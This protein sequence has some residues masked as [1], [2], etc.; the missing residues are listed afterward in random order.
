MKNT[1]KALMKRILFTLGILALYRLGSTLP[2]PGIDT[3]AMS[4]IMS[5]SSVF[6]VL[7]MI[8]GGALERMSL[9]ALGVSPY[10]TA[11]IIIELLSM[12]VIPAL[13]EWRKGG[14]PG[15]NKL[16]NATRYLG[17]AL[18]ALQ[19]V[20]IVRGFDK[21]YGILTNSSVSSYLFV[22]TMLVAGTEML[23]WLGD[24]ITERGIGNGMSMII[25]AGIVANLPAQF[26]GAF[27]TLAS[28]ASSIT[29][30]ILKFALYCAIYLLLIL[31]VV[32][33]EGSERRIP[34]SYST[35]MNVLGGSQMNY[36]P[37]KINSASVIPVIFAASVITAPQIILS[38][39]NYGAYEKLADTLS[40]NKPLGLILYAALTFGFTFFYTDLVMD[41]EQIAADLKKNNGFI[42]NVRPGKDTE[43][44]IKG[45]LHRIT[46]F[47][48]IG[49][50]VLA[51]IPYL[52]PMLIKSLPSTI[53]IG[54]T[55]VILIVGIALETV[56]MMQTAGVSDKYAYST[57]M[58]QTDVQHWYD[59]KIA[60]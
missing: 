37:F 1:T 33:V 5:G 21:Q 11:S 3:T 41:P 46:V 38:F 8:G 26:S 59:S 58:H 48:A 53:G 4:A 43:N 55:S 39:I 2:V 9:F 35:R 10:I 54:G 49:L 25:F 14:N 6:A 42:P 18:A 47:G 51:V 56:K 40:F 20:G 57:F 29:V 32:I 27:S 44:Y 12:D 30:G 22:I 31:A 52:L 7:N 24:Q 23:C 50:T 34:I 36:M 60:K 28:G 15:R 17:L 16:S 19:A 13:S 45:I